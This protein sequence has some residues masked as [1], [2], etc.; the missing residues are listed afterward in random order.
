MVDGQTQMRNCSAVNPEYAGLL[1]LR[2]TPSGLTVNA[3]HCFVHTSQ[4][5]CEEER[6]TL[7]KVYTQ[8]YVELTRLLNEATIMAN[9]SACEDAVESQYRGQ[10]SPL[11][12]E[13]DELLREVS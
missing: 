4:E 1:L 5:A 8:A 9:S 11:Q 13:A 12:Q 3:S 10:K 2:C 7:E 6:E